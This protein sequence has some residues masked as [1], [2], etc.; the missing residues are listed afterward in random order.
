M[1]LLVSRSVRI[2]DLADRI[3][4]FSSRVFP[5]TSGRDVHVTPRENTLHAAQANSCM[6]QRV[7]VARRRR[8][9]GLRITN[10]SP[11]SASFH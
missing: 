6:H 3:T 7:G 4:T 10:L 1:H 2:G 8:A 9:G 5:E 11:L